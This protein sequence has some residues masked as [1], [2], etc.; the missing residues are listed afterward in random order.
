M[1]EIVVCSMKKWKQAKETVNNSREERG[2][3]VD[4]LLKRWHVYGVHIAA[5]PRLYFPHFMNEDIQ[6]KRKL[7]G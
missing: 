2:T 3:A 6:R 5:H 4:S 1:Y 7:G